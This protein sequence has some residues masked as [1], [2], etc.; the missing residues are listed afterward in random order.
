M[1]VRTETVE[2]QT[3]APLFAR[4]AK[5][6]RSLWGRF[7]KFEQP[8]ETDIRKVVEKLQVKLELEGKSGDVIQKVGKAHHTAVRFSNEAFSQCMYIIKY[9]CFCLR[10]LVFPFRNQACLR[11]D[12]CEDVN[13]HL[14]IY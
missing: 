3:P 12:M 11:T 4:T 2:H 9:I 6:W 1:K 13:E 10:E 8:T 5:A 14:I 7:R